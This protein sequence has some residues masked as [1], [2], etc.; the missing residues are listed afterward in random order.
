MQ[1]EGLD[2][3]I[4][5]P[6]GKLGLAAVEGEEFRSPPLD[7]LGYY[8]RVVRLNALPIVG[9]M[10]SVVAVVRQPVDLGLS[11]TGTLIERLARA[12]DGRFSYR[13]GAT[14]GLTALVLTPEPIGPGDDAALT[15]VLAQPRRSRVVPLG[16]FRLNLGQEAMAMA[17]RPAADGLLPDPETLADA[18]VDHFRRFVPLMVL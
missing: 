16:L 3:L 5:G 15:E 17:L 14:I 13:Q 4:A 12:L 1:I 8:H 10:Q 18:L 9:R 11:G 2:E 7:V 6:L